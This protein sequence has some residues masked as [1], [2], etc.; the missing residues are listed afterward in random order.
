[1]GATR[2][3]GPRGCHVNSHIVLALRGTSVFGVFRV[4]RFLS[5]EGDSL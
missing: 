5:P 2:Y 4:R 3:L 1:M